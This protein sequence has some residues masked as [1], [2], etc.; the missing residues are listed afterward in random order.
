MTAVPQRLF[1]KYPSAGAYRLLFLD[2]GHLAQTFCLLATALGLGPFTTAAIRH[3]RI[4]K[5]LGLDGIGEFP[6]YVCGAGVPRLSGHETA[7][8]SSTRR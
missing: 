2:A 8:S 5:L 6:I 3:S 7:P 4:E 1:W